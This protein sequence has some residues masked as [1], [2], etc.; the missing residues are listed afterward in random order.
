MNI[1][2]ITQTYK[3]SSNIVVL[4]VQKKPKIYI[5]YKIPAKYVS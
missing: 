2:T 3:L 1:P 4:E 5:I